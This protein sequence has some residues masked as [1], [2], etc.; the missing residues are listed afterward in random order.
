MWEDN[1]VSHHDMLIM[2]LGFVVVLGLLAQTDLRRCGSGK[3]MIL[4]LSGGRTGACGPS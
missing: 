4:G 2:G 1:R 3:R